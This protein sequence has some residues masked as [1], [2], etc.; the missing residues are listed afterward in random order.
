MRSISG[1]YVCGLMTTSTHSSDRALRRKQKTR[2]DTAAISPQKP[3]GT[4]VVGTKVR[5]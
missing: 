2:A 5:R 4:K 3:V 1:R